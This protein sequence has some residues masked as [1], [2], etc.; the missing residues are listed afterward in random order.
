LKNDDNA[1]KFKNGSGQELLSLG[2]Y[3]FPETIN[4]DRTFQ[5]SFYVMNNLKENPILVID[6]LSPNNVKIN[7]KNRQINYYHAAAEQLLETD[8]SIYSLT[9][10]DD[11]TEIP[12]IAYDKPY[13]NR[14]QVEIPDKLI[15][16][17]NRYVAY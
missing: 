9:I 15:T 16:T 14:T 8:C 6:F 7:L 1:P 5:H 3:E 12:L 13:I 4:K 2:K 11:Q 10:R 17:N